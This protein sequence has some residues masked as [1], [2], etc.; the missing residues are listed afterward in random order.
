MIE[1]CDPSRPSGLKSIV[2]ILYLNQLDVRKAI[3]DLLYELI[4]LPQII[5]TDEYSVALSLVDP[6]DVQDA[7]LLSSG[8]VAMEGRCILPSLANR[9]PNISEQNLAII[10]Y[11]FLETGLLSALVE[12]IVSSD[13]YISVRA[14]ILVGKL[15]HLMHTHLPAD[16]CSTCQALPT[17]ISYAV[18]GNNQA[19]AAINALHNY[20]QMLKNRPASASLFLDLIIRSGALINSKL[21]KR[22]IGLG[23]YFNQSGTFEDRRRRLD[24]NASSIS[25][26]ADDSNNSFLAN[27]TTASS[28]TRGSSFRM[29]RI[30][31]ISKYF[32]Q[33]REFDRLLRESRVMLQDDSNK[34]DWDVVCTMFNSEAM[35]T[36]LDDTKI[37]FLRRLIIFYKP[38]SFKFSHQDL[39]NG[40]G[41]LSVVIAGLHLIDWLL[42]S[43]DVSFF[44]FFKL[45]EVLFSLLLT[46]RKYANADG[47]F[48]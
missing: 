11:C 1:F 30:R 25:G 14:T 23:E 2:D 24:S 40:K 18:Q 41:V 31:K 29:K 48:L 9:V 37:R 5:W 45:F 8:F 17:L 42:A 28:L 10:L 12:V 7:W 27:T 46:A 38:T 22:D 26:G 3:L 43:K 35:G 39:P 16:I 32:D 36:K 19:N 13:T 20:H 44:F 6:S 4:G 47:S 21:F 15:L 34:W 33:I